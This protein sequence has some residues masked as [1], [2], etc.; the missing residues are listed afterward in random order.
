MKRG[1][2][3]LSL[4]RETLLSLNGESLQEAVGGASLRCASVS[5]CH[6]CATTPANTCGCTA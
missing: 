1:I 2:R 3:K 5:L 6:V 4:H